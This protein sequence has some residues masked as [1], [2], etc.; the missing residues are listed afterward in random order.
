MHP[1]QLGEVGRVGGGGAEG[2]LGQAGQGRDGVVADR[3]PHHPVEPGEE[4]LRVRVPAEPEVGGQ[5]AQ[6]A[7]RVGEPGEERDPGHEG[8]R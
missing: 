4:R 3:V 2:I 7:E 1:G 5:L 8:G 6:R